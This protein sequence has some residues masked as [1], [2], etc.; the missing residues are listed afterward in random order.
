MPA[1]SSSSWGAVRV[2]RAAGLAALR[3]LFV[4]RPDGR[5]RALLLRHPLLPVPFA[6]ERAF[7]C[8]ALVQ[9]AVSVAQ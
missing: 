6:L 9:R 5:T 3:A 4:T 1:R 8:G 2:G 7:M